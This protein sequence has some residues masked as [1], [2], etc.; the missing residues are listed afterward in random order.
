MTRKGKLARLPQ[1]IREQINL[2]LQDG[3]EAKQI[4]AWLNTLPE[5]RSLLA[6][7]FDGQPINEVNLSNWKLGGYRDW[8]AQQEALEAVRQFSSDAA[9]LSRAVPGGQPGRAAPGAPFADQLALCLTARI[10]VALKKLPSGE[11]DPATQLERLRQ[12]CMR[13]V[14]L[15]KGDH[16]AQWLQIERGKLDLQ[17]KKYKEEAADRKR[18]NDP[19]KH[20]KKGGIPKK[21]LD[22]IEKELKFL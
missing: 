3:A 22:Y 11:A 4:A 21:V 6:K 7:E 8:E 16:H 17:I 9:E 2:R 20:R 18:A 1:T 15:R 5:V 12:L 13:L 14:A 10:A 19:L